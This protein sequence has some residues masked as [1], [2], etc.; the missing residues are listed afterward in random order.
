[1]KKILIKLIEIYQKHISPL[2]KRNTCMF[3]PTCSQY[4]KEALIKHGLFKGIILS[5]Y[6]ILRCNPFN[7]NGGYDPVPDVFKLF[8]RNKK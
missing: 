4:A 8:R 5:F 6:R 2:K 7:H 3:I 1:M